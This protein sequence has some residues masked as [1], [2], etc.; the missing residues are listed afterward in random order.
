MKKYI[1]ILLFFCSI[2]L[3]AQEYILRAGKEVYKFNEKT[4]EWSKNPLP[5]NSVLSQG[6]SIKS[7]TA[8]T[9]EVPRSLKNLFSQRYFTIIKNPDGIRLSGNLVEKTDK[10]VPVDTRVVNQGAHRSMVE[11]IMWIM[12]NGESLTSCFDVQMDIYDSQTWLPIDKNS[13]VSLSNASTRLSIVNNEPDAMYVY[14]FMKDTRWHSYFNI[15]QCIKLS[16]YSIYD[17]PLDLSKPLGEQRFIMICSKSIITNKTVR[18][19]LRRRYS[20]KR[21]SGFD[22]KIG[23]DNTGFMLEP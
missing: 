20:A 13:T 11:H 4:G 2:P 10:Y 16:S 6:D 1:L 23:F 15:N 21:H 8:F 9:L 5:L 3:C 22:L 12:E 19:I 17:E 18:A 7:N 14:V